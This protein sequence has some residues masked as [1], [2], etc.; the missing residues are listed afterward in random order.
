MKSVM[1]FCEVYLP[2]YLPRRPLRV[3]FLFLFHFGAI[4][5]SAWALLL[6]LGAIW[7]ARG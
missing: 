5:R 4:P 2:E 6:A 7:N 3:S 1:V